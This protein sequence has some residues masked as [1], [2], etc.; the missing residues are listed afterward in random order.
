MN[1]YLIFKDVKAP[2]KCPKCKKKRKM[3]VH[4]IND[5]TSTPIEGSEFTVNCPTYVCSNCDVVVGDARMAI[6]QHVADLWM[7]Q[8][9]SNEQT[10]H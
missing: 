1:N 3:V 9:T 10:R 4:W 2:K 8:G 7:E 6:M 5:T